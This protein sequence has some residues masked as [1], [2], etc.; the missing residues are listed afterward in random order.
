MKRGFSSFLTCPRCGAKVR[1]TARF[2]PYCRTP[3]WTVNVVGL[4]YRKSQLKPVTR[5]GLFLV[6]LSIFVVLVVVLLVVASKYIQL[7]NEYGDLKTNYGSLERSYRDVSYKYRQLV[8]RYND[9]QDDFSELKSEYSDLEAR[10]QVLEDNYRNLSRVLNS[11]QGKTVTITYRWRFSTS[12]TKYF[13]FSDEWTWEIPVPLTY[14]LYYASA[15]RPSHYSEW[16]SMVKDS[17][18][19]PLIAKT[20]EC[21]NTVAYKHDFT[22]KQKIEF[23]VAFIQSLPYVPDEVSASADE[24]P[25][26]PA[27][28]LI[29][30]GGDCEDTSILAAALLRKMG[31]RVALL[32]L[33]NARHAAVGVAGPFSGFYYEKDGVKYY[34]LETTGEG[35][36]IGEI[37]SAITDTRA[38]VYPVD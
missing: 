32:I 3:L 28:T 23:T 11:L 7:Q 15:D 37:P 4:P 17:Y 1:Q 18:G 20:V 22:E 29:T 12:W 27:E 34:Y 2:C 30:N 13:G 5:K 36:E 21:I 31:Y 10:Y 19:E 16:T 38:Y 6:G 24:Y 8:E 9:L 26:Y 25:K 35:W 14:Y 33:P